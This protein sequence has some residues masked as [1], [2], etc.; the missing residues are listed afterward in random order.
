MGN[1]LIDTFHHHHQITRS[2]H[3]INAIGYIPYNQQR[4]TARAATTTHLCHD[5][6]LT[7]G[8]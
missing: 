7:S 8:I 1:Q 4:G 5:L 2:S 6:S 3:S